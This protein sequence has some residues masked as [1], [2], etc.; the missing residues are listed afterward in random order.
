[1]SSRLGLMLV[2]CAPSGTGKSTLTARLRAEFP[3]LGYSVSCTTRSPRPGEVDGRDYHFL[4]HDEFQRRR[5]AGFFAEWAE[6]HGNC[7]GTPRQA[8]AD[9]L[10]A[11]QDVLFDIDVQGAA[12]LRAS[13]GGCHVFLMPP[14][15][16]ALRARLLGRASDDEVVIRKRL[17]NA[18]GELACAPDFDYWIVNDDLD[19]AYDRL[20]AVYL[21][22]G[23]RPAL[24]PGLL[25]TVLHGPRG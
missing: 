10:A 3:R 2:I 11:G 18:P 23:L 25:E 4:E 22:E 6:V 20:R 14:S 12:Q 1:M 21:A 15:L 7:Y 8:L 17:G 19:A 5:K 16:D 24:N 13:M 9:M